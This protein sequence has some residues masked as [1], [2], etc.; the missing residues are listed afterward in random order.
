MKY[1]RLIGKAEAVVA[2]GMP[3]LYRVIAFFGVQKIYSLGELG[4]AASAFSV[5]QILAYFTAIGWA[6]L[7]LVRVPAARGRDAAIQRFYELLCMGG[8]SAVVVC[9]GVLLWARFFG[10][11]ISGNEIIAILIGWSVYQLTRH[12][13]L[14]HR[15][16]RRV[17]AYDLVLLSATASFVVALHR[18]GVP[19]GWPLGIAL[20]AVGIFMLMNIGWPGRLPQGWKFEP[21]GLEFGFTNFLSGGIALSLVPIANI[22]DGARFAG[23]ISL[24]ASFSLISALIPRAISMYRLPEL[25]RL[26][27][28]GQPLTMLTTQTAREVALACGAA[29]LV[30]S[31]I[32]LM[33][34]LYKGADADAFWY[35]L[36][37]GLAICAQGCISM[38]GMAYSSVLMVREESRMSV[39]INLVSCGAFVAALGAFY[40]STG[41]L[42]FPFTLAVCLAITLLRNVMLKRQSASLLL[43]AA[44]A[45]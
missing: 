20:A 16:Y 31:A 7:I 38:L 9:A 10:S 8:V 11:D 40:L 43:P 35:T 15:K 6:S 17:I 34:V 21:K 1:G 39:T 41:K 23:V 2:T 18:I 19:A 42:S 33:I 14:A 37:C 3:G 44:V 36:I 27:S 28:D 13:F 30:N 45:G 25:S 26:V 12:Y 24:I 4:T 22:A 29:F 32:V 5:A